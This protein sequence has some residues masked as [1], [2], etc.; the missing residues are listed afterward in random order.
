VISKDD[1]TVLRLEED[2]LLW[3]ATLATAIVADD[4]ARVY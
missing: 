2:S 4:C 3:V 1:A